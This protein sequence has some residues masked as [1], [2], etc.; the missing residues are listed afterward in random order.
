MKST[1]AL[2]SSSA[3][4]G[5]QRRVLNNFRTRP[6]I[7]CGLQIAQ[8]QLPKVQPFIRY[9][10]AEEKK[11]RRSQLQQKVEELSQKGNEIRDEDSGAATK[12]GKIDDAISAEFVEKQARTPWHREGAEERPVDKLENPPKQMAK[13]RQAGHTIVR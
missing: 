5:V 4:R 2:F 10:S 9:Y 6:A 3:L 7:S 8:P 11:D 12:D 1:T 13:G